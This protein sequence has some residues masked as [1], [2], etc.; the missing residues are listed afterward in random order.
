MELFELI[1]LNLHNRFGKL[2]RD[3]PWFDVFA[4]IDARDYFQ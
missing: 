3:P 2:Q 4:N 1:G